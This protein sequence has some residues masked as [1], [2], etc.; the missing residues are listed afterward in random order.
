MQSSQLTVVV[1]LGKTGLSCVEFL[2]KKGVN[3]AVTDS[4]AEPPCLDELKKQFPQ[5]ATSMGAFDAAMVM[6]ASELIVSPGVALREPVIAKAIA[7]GIP[8]IG[9]IELFARYVKAPVIGIT[10]T[11]GKSTVT[12][13]VGEMAKQAG[14]N[15]GVGGNLGTPVLEMLQQNFEL[16]VLELSSF[17]LETTHTLK[18]VAATVLNITPDHMDRYQNL[19]EYIAAKQRIFQHCKVAIINREDPISY[20]GLTNQCSETKMPLISFG[21]NEPNDGE[22]GIRQ[23]KHDFYLAYGD[24]NLLSVNKLQIKGKHQWANALAALALG[25]AYGLPME[26]MLKALQTFPGLAHRCQWV[27]NLHGVDW[28]NDS[29]GTNVN[30]TQAAIEGLGGIISGKLI[31]L[32]GGLGKQQDFSPLHEPVHEHVRTVILFGHDAELIAAAL[33]NA[34]TLLFAKNFAE[35]IELAKQNAQAGDA[36]LLSPACAS[37]DMFTNFEHRGEVFIDLVQHLS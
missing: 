1:G 24:E 37:F 29:K 17:Q 3:V 4:R 23:I 16:Y 2:A 36:V 34:C 7:K 14:L 26:A 35:A 5:V 20:S 11:N 18:T 15:V 6:S 30:S 28:Y 33:A 22:F 27:R 19:E 8:A 21:L 31:L 32:A 10:G 13:L 12:S 25:H 9:D